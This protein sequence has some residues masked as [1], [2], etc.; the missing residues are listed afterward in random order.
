MRFLNPL[1]LLAIAATLTMA[2]ETPKRPELSLIYSMEALLGDRFSLGPVPNGEERIV[3]PI[4]GGT[5]K[6]PRIS[7]KLFVGF[8]ISDCLRTGTIFYGI[9]SVSFPSPKNLHDVMYESA[10]ILIHT[11]KAK[12]SILVQTGVSQM[13]MGKSVRTLATTYRPTMER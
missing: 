2:Q 13:R 9:S 5:F 11:F 10:A 12:Y 3:I 4:M 6:G 7:G 8:I 1:I